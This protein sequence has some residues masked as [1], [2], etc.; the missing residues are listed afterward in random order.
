M[1]ETDSLENALACFNPKRNPSLAY[2]TKLDGPRG[3]QLNED[4]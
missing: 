1:K 2:S 4:E 3:I